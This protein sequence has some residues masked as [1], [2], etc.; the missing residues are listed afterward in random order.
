MSKMKIVDLS[1]YRKGK[2][3]TG[4]DSS[5]SNTNSPSFEKK[6]QNMIH[7]PFSKTDSQKDLIALFEEEQFRKDNENEDS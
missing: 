3:Q 7:R 5:Q 2:E 6:L 1:Q 4:N